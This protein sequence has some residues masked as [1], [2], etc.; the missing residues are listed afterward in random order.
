MY[1]FD[2]RIDRY[3][4]NQVKYDFV[5]RVAEGVRV[6]ALP[7]WIADMD[8]AAYPP[9]IEALQARVERRTFGYSLHKTNE[10][11]GAIRGWLR[12]RFGWEVAD[13]D[14]CYTPGMMTAIAFLIQGLSA[15]G[16]GVIIQPPVY[17]SFAEVIERNG[18]RVVNNPLTLREDGG[19]EMNFVELEAQ[20]RLP[21]N[22]ILLLCSPHNPVGRIWREDELRRVGELC[23]ENGVFLVSDESHCDL[24]RRG[25]RHVPV[26]QLFPHSPLIATCMTP[27][28]TFS[29]SGFQ[30]GYVLLQD[31]G[32]REIWERESM[33]V[34]IFH[35]NALA[36]TALQAV[37][38]DCR[39]YYER[40]L[41]YLDENLRLVGE[42]LKEEMPR[43]RY[44]LPE[45]T[46][47]CW[48]DLRGYG[49]PPQEI[50]ER[51]LYRGNVVPDG[52]AGFGQGGE[53]FIRLNAGCP[54][55]TLMEGLQRLRKAMED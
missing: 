38:N 8:F 12:Y 11:F 45:A 54:R 52:G 40:S 31:E 24:V 27:S 55:E 14:I 30:I 36:I 41:D 23:A 6:D 39:E 21:E 44:R 15:P 48:I 35:P 5:G 2:E 46:Y 20:L 51:C 18:R 7:M 26:Q 47:L 13:E 50:M 1:Q 32:L 22:K 28:K 37:Y 16:E 33:K 25:L 4:C 42:F 17:D 9:L 49:Y 53:G 34:H 29:V 19:Y 43:A 10:F 3:G